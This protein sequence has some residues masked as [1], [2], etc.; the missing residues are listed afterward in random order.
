MKKPIFIISILVILTVSLAIAKAVFSNVLS[1][2]GVEASKI[3]SEIDRYKTENLLLME[4]L[5]FKKSLHNVASKAGELG[6]EESKSQLVIAETEV[7]T[8][9]LP[10]VAKR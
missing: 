6:F 5:Y 2:S 3:E 1:T 8:R 4:K 7:L 10:H 9:F